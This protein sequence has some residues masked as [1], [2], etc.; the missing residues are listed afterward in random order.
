MSTAIEEWLRS[1]MRSPK[2]PQGLAGKSVVHICAIMKQLFKYAVKWGYISR[3]PMGTKELKLVELPRGATRRQGRPRSLT[4]AEFARLLS[5]YGIRER[6]A[7]AMEAWTGGARTN[8]AFGLKWRDLDLL[9]RVVD[10]QRGFV[11]GH[12][13]PLKTEASREQEPLP[14]D[15]YELLVAW[16]RITPYRAPDD[17]IFA[18]PHT[19]G[20]RPYWPGQLLKDHIQPVALKAGLGKLGWHT[21]RHSYAAWAKAAGLTGEQ[22]RHLMRHQNEKMGE[23]YGE[24]DMDAKRQDSQKVIDHV[25]RAAGV[26]PRP[27]AIVKGS[28]KVQ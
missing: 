1:L 27:V 25:K 16:R 24:P 17:W 9:N 4:P 8:E 3:S 28:D 14:D 2:N 12:V 7:I 5:L 20:K 18:S 21:L 10:F 19:D 23:V 11:A 22:R 13:S 15:V 26:E 6:L